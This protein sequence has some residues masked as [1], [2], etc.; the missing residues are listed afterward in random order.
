MGIAQRLIGQIGAWFMEQ[1]ARRI[2]VNVEPDNVAA[3]SFYQRCGAQSLKSYWM[4]W[5]GPRAMLGCK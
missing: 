2:C 5:E 1:G 3:R 4:V